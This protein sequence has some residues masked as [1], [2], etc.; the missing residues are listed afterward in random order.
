MSIRNQKVIRR[1]LE[2]K[3]IKSGLPSDR[4]AYTKQCKYYNFLPTNAKTDFF[5]TKMCEAKADKKRLFN[6]AKEI[7]CWK[8]E[9]TFP[10]DIKQ[11]QLLHDFA[12]YFID[13]I[14]E[15]RGEISESIINDAI[16]KIT[17]ECHDMKQ[18]LSDFTPAA[19]EEIAILLSN[20]SNFTSRPNRRFKTM[21]CGNNSDFNKNSEPFADKC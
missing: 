8:E 10:M 14:V 2:R 5:S 19:E 21:C 7:L 16:S 6:T 18:T 4:D 11:E 20:P 13:K 15:I 3:M 17:E 9:S 12:N 1:R